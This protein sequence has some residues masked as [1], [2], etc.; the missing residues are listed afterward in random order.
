MPARRSSHAQTPAFRGP[1]AQP[2]GP[3]PSTRT[4]A[5][6]RG[7]RWRLLALGS[8]APDAARQQPAVTP[9]FPAAAAR[10]GAWLGGR[11]PLQV[12]TGTGA[13]PPMGHAEA[14]VAGKG[15]RRDQVRR[16]RR[17]ASGGD[18]LIAS[19]PPSHPTPTPALPFCTTTTT[20]TVPPRSR[21]G[22]RGTGA[23]SRP[24]E[25]AA[26]RP[27]GGAPHPG[28]RAGGRRPLVCPAPAHWKA[29]SA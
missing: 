6:C 11:D 23:L 26:Q 22:Y 9:S 17:S 7:S 19:R 18:S 3:F 29:V 15:R 5:R 28:A 16:P 24:R 25:T 8:R 4:P 13:A 2:P 12:R 21:L 27:G 20:T 14:L 10:R 1:R